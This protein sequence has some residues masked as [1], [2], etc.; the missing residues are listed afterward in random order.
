LRRLLLWLA[1]KLLLVGLLW[2]LLLR[3]LLLLWNLLLR[4]LL[5]RCLLLLWNLLLRC[6]LLLW[7]LLLRCLLLWLADWLFPLARPLRLLGGEL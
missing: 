3:C 6:L 2:S 4:C 7:N 5:L 1:T